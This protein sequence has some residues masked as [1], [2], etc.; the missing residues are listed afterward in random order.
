MRVAPA[1]GRHAQE[2]IRAAKRDGM[3]I[4]PD[5]DILSDCPSESIDYAV[6][7]HASERRGCAHVARLVRSW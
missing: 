3:R 6:M 5:V 2:A 4:T 1:I 7:E